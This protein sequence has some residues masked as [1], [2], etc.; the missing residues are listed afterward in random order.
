MIFLQ[1]GIGFY[2]RQRYSRVQIHGF[3]YVLPRKSGEPTRPGSLIEGW[4]RRI[5][6]RCGGRSWTARMP[7]RRATEIH[8][9]MWCGFKGKPRRSRVGIKD[10]NSVEVEPFAT[11]IGCYLANRTAELGWVYRKRKFQGWVGMFLN[12]IIHDDHRMD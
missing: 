2:I 1:V 10:Q 6:N 4:Y 9:F 8:N 12:W 5:S 11:R 7:A 3:V